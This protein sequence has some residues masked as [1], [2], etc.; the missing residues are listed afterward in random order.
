MFWLAA[1]TYRV[2]APA[3]FVQISLFFIV[4]SA[5]YSIVALVFQAFKFFIHA[6]ILQ[7][8][9]DFSNSKLCWA[10][11]QPN[12]TMSTSLLPNRHIFLA[13]LISQ[14]TEQHIIH[15]NPHFARRE[16]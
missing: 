13:E 12:R 5:F 4:E 11:D 7:C 8:I 16:G 15:G 2:V 10:P 6:F 9:S 3:F 14:L 1:L